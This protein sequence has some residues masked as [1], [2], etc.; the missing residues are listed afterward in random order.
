MKMIGMRSLPALLLALSFQLPAQTFKIVSTDVTACY[1]N[2]NIIPCPALPSQPFFGQYP[3]TSLPSF[4]SNSNGTVTDL[5]TG[6]TWQR[7]PDQ[8]GNNNGV[9]TKTDKLT[10]PQ[11]Q[12][13]VAALNA[14]N[15]GGFSDWRVPLIKEL[16]SLTN[17]N[18]TDPSGYNGTSTV[19]FTPFIDTN[20]FQF[21]YGDQAAGER[22]IDSQYAS[23]DMYNELSFS[24]SQQLFGFNFADGRI[25]GYDLL[26]PGGAQKVFSLIAV[27]GNNAYGQNSFTDNGDGTV[28]D[29]ATGLM[30]TK[31][32]SQSAMNWEAALAWAQTKNAAGW[33]GHNDWRLPNAKELQSIVDYTRSPG[34]TASAAIDPVFNCSPILNEAGRADFPWFWTSTTH[35]S[36]D[37][38]ASHGAWAVYVCF[39]RA[40][41]WMKKIGNTYYSLVDVHGAGAQ[42]S[43]PKSGTFVGN[44]MGVDSL[45]HPVYGLG[46]QGDVLRVSNYVRLVRDA[47][48]TTGTGRTETGKQGLLLSPVPVREVL[49]VQTARPIVNGNLELLDATGQMVLSRTIGLA[50]PVRIDC[51]RMP[52]GLYFVRIC[53][54]GESLMGRFIRQ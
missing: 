7:S 25:K 20:Y 53:S 16:F 29:G 17:W 1:D 4:Q 14:S 30:W 22:I 5:V 28:T 18:G 13:R 12:A 3:G 21:A 51:S 35:I 49:T 2:A 37:G 26:M 48:G 39:G 9:I 33:C 27:R 52:P 8:N 32:D 24:G 38:T 44:Y 23:S 11:V 10:W 45:G 43:S 31:D 36:N 50:E 54:E 6:L 19:S 46:P 34:T 42:R 47:P 15:W 41:G 40:V